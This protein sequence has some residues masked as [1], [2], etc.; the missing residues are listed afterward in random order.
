MNINT[1]LSSLFFSFVKVTRR[2][3]M[4]SQFFS[5]C[6]RDKKKCFFIQK[7]FLSPYECAK[8]KKSI[9]QIVVLLGIM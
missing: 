6:E 5:P 3:K 7:P 9:L 2:K 4:Y 8:K 1:K